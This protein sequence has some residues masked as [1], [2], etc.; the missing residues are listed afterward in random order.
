MYTVYTYRG[1]YISCFPQQL[2]SRGLNL[3]IYRGVWFIVGLVLAGLGRACT[4]HVRSM[5]E[6]VQNTASFVFLYVSDIMLSWTSDQGMGPYAGGPPHNIQLSSLAC[7]LV[8]SVGL[9]ASSSRASLWI[10]LLSGTK[11]SQFCKQYLII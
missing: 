1:I 6:H 11:C 10:G 2:C 5:F 7:G 3:E 9:V 4:E 8:M